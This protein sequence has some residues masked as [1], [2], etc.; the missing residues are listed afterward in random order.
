MRKIALWTGVP[1]VVGLV[2]LWFAL[3]PARSVGQGS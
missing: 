1:A 2:G 3:V